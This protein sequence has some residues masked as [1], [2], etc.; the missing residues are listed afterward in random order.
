[1]ENNST[2]DISVFTFARGSQLNPKIMESESYRFVMSIITTMM[3]KNGVDTPKVGFGGTKED[4]SCFVA[5]LIDYQLMYNIDIEFEEGDT[6]EFD[7]D[8]SPELYDDELG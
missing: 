3:K 4:L 7:P 1:M 2:K 6:S 8:V 5:G